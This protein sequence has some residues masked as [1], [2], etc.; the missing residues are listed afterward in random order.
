L[1]KLSRIKKPKLI[2]V[3]GATVEEVEGTIKKLNENGKKEICLVHGFQS[4]PTAIKE[5]NLNL[6]ETYK[7]KFSVPVG[8]A[9][10]VDGGSELALIVPLIAV[11]KGANIIEKHLTHD[12]KLKGLDYES[13]LDPEDFVKMIRYIKEIETSFGKREFGSL[14]ENELNYRLVVRKRCVAARD[15]NKGEALSYENITLK[16][17]NDGIYPEEL[18]ALIGKKAIKS[19]SKDHPITKDIA[20]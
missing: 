8:F 11:A 2:R 17:A 5:M 19:L 16:R 13:A 15:I 10:H 18:E 4:F 6:I 9:D 20:R 7:T 12:R 14:S 1:E 3:G